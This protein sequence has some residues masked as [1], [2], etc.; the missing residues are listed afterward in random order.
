MFSKKAKGNP[1]V[2][3][4]SL[5]IAHAVTGESVIATNVPPTPTCS[6]ADS[7]T[8]LRARVPLALKR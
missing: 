6:D 5:N 4:P 7:I 3:A 2:V 8:G 1:R